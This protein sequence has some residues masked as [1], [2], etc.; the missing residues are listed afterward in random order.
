MVMHLDDLKLG[1]LF[2][3]RHLFLY[4][5]ELNFESLLDVS[6]NQTPYH[7]GRVLF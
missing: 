4:V 2:N 7:A 1:D 6:S 5:L 3:D